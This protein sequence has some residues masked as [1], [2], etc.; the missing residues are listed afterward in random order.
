MPLSHVARFLEL[1]W[2]GPSERTALPVY[3]V[4]GRRQD[5]SMSS[6]SKTTPQAALSDRKFIKEDES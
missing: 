2:L 1:G 6:P 3:K 5:N 4:A